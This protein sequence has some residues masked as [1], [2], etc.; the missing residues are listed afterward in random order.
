MN[1]DILKQLRF[2][3]ELNRISCGHCPICNNKIFINEF[4][5]SLSIKEF[6]ISGLC[7]NCQDRIFG[8]K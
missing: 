1:K 4:R 7:Q 6:R 5:D 3:E 2:T 8:V